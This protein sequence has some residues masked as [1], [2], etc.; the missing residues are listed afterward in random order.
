[1]QFDPGAGLDVGEAVVLVQQQGQSG[2]LAEMGGRGAA[3][4]ELLRLGQE[5]GRAAGAVA[6]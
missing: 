5:F 6:G 1:M 2:A 3:A 4:K